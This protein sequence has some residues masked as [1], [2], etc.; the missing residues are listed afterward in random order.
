MKKRN[1]EEEEESD[2]EDKKRK[3]KSVEEELEEED[4]KKRSLKKRSDKE[5]EEEESNDKKKKKRTLKKR[6]NGEIDDEDDEEDKENDE[7]DEEGEEEDK[8]KK[9]KRSNLEILREDQIL[10]GDIGD[11]KQKKSIQW[12]KYFGLDR[13]KKD[14]R[15][16]PLNFYKNF[17]EER[18]INDLNEEK[19]DNMDEKL[20]TIEDM[21]LSKTVKY[22]GDHEGRSPIKCVLCY[23]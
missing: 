16:Y 2:D 21:I 7:N 20:K 18:R 1:D 11:L 22:T 15:E 5:E 19:L 4:E 14:G 17:E 12:N 13:K 10:P 8:K 6:Q 3:K 9:K 23:L